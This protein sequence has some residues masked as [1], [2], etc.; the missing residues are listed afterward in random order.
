M[1]TS[2]GGD[3]GESYYIHPV[4]ICRQ[5]I[6]QTQAEGLAETR[7]GTTGLWGRFRHHILAQ[8]LLSAVAPSNSSKVFGCQLPRYTTLVCNRGLSLSCSV[9][10]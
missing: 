4:H 10:R 1:F 5:R 6:E 2:G 9:N 3:G 8:S 7:E